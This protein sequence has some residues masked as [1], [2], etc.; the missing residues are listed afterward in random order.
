MNENI[1]KQFFR[2]LKEHGALTS[3]I[4][5]LTFKKTIRTASMG[6]FIDSRK[7]SQW[8]ISAFRWDRTQK[9][10]DFWAD[11]SIEWNILLNKNY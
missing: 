3:Y 10:V 6:C 5:E 11:L 1:K 8:I 7:P 9:G 2:F 4:Y